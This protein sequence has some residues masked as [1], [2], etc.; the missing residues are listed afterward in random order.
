MEDMT[1]ELDQGRSHGTEQND[2]RM[3]MSSS[4]VAKRCASYSDSLFLVCAKHLCRTLEGL[5]L[6]LHPVFF[7]SASGHDQMFHLGHYVHAAT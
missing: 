2:G 4:R 1:L 3:D 5:C 6:E 7:S